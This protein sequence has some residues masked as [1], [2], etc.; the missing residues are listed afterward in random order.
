ML[1][2][3]GGGGT[4]AVSYTRIWIINLDPYFIFIDT[5]K[6]KFKKIEIFIFGFNRYPTK[7]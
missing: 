1:A 4:G 3:G 6:I 5:K 7:K 2:R